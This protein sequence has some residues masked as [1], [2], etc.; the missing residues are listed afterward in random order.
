MSKYFT[1]IDKRRF[2]WKNSCK[3]KNIL[4]R[5]GK[6]KFKKSIH[7]KKTLIGGKRGYKNRQKGNN[8]Y[9]FIHLRCSKKLLMQQ[10]ILFRKYWWRRYFIK[11]KDILINKKK[12]TWRNVCSTFRKDWVC[13]SRSFWIKDFSSDSITC[14]PN[15]RVSKKFS[16]KKFWTNKK[17]FFY[18]FR[19]FSFSSINSVIK[20]HYYCKIKKF[21]L[22]KLYKNK[23]FYKQWRKKYLNKQIQLFYRKEVKNQFSLLYNSFYNNRKILLKQI[24]LLFNNIN[25]F[26]KLLFFNKYFNLYIKN[27]NLTTTCFYSSFFF[28]IQNSLFCTLKND[29]SFS[30]QNNESLIIFF[31]NYIKDKNFSLY[32][33]NV[34]QNNILLVKH[35]IVKYLFNSTLYNNLDTV[36]KQ[37]FLFQP[38]V[39]FK[40]LISFRPKYTRLAFRGVPRVHNKMFWRPRPWRYFGRRRRWK[41]YRRQFTKDRKLVRR[42]GKTLIK[43]VKRNGRIILRPLRLRDYL[44]PRS[45]WRTRGSLPKYKR[46]KSQKIWRFFKKIDRTYN[47]FEPRIIKKKHFFGRFNRIRNFLSW[48]FKIR[49]NRLQYYQRSI[50]NHWQYGGLSPYLLAFINKPERVLLK[51]HPRVLKEQFNRYT[52]NFLKI[53]LNRNTKQF[54][55]DNPLYFTV[56]N[57][58]PINSWIVP[59][60]MDYTQ[61]NSLFWGGQKHN[62]WLMNRASK[63]YSLQIDMHTSYYPLKISRLLHYRWNSKYSRYRYIDL[64]NPLNKERFTARFGHGWHRK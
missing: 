2:W 4:T 62:S 56:S 10:Y 11:N 5:R 23:K 3:K 38:I 34:I 9:L 43:I 33:Y 48:K 27:K 47:P 29:I 50:K 39:N 51:V 64:T 40:S 46:R 24:L 36:L 15:R 54:W 57:L 59:Q 14:K 35:L 32:N 21:Y 42:N 22:K 16:S 63:Q 37:Q 17:K 52:K 55:F 6:I 49:I 26:N 45:L 53:V 61:T 20:K 44:G 19:Q 60:Y 7:Y 41:K 31:Y 58:I 1:K 12:L 8:K 30:A 13:Y 25:F 28:L 18:L